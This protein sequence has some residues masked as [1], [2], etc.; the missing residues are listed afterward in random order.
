MAGHSSWM[1]TSWADKLHLGSTWQAPL[2]A[3]ASVGLAEARSA[4]PVFWQVAISDWGC[5]GLLA[6]ACERVGVGIHWMPRY[7]PVPYVGL[8][9]LRRDGWFR[10]LTLPCLSVWSRLSSLCRVS[11]MW[12]CA[13]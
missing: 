1:Q 12:W 2:P 11:W 8:L 3:L 10:A 13:A 6:H 9:H 5:I 7:R 4:C